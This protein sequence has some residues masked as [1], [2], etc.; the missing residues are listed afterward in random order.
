M[1]LPQSALIWSDQYFHWGLL[2]PGFGAAAQREEL[3]R[4]RTWKRFRVEC[5][6]M[7]FTLAI[8]EL[9]PVAAAVV[10]TWELAGS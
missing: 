2:E 10:P 9:E 7:Q 3:E 1:A 4:L 5:R 8:L 6:W